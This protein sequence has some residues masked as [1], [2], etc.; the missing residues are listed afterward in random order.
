MADD[1]PAPDL[2][3]PNPNPN[4]N[5]KP[6]P[7]IRWDFLA[8]VTFVIAL[9]FISQSPLLGSLVLF[10]AGTI[11]PV[12]VFGVIIYGNSD[13]R[14]FAIGAAVPTLVM[15]CQAVVIFMLAT[16][17]EW[18]DLRRFDGTSVA[19]PLLFALIPICGGMAVLTRRGV[20]WFRPNDTRDEP[21]R[22]P[23]Q[24]SLRSMIIGTTLAA[25]VC[26]VGMMAREWSSLILLCVMF[27]IVMLSTI[28]LYLA[29]SSD[30]ERAK[31]WRI[32]AVGASVPVFMMFAT[33][34]TTMVIAMFDD[35]SFIDDRNYNSG[36]KIGLP[37]LS[38]MAYGGGRLAVWLNRRLTK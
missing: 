6:Y 24:F 21:S 14:L 38:A 2:A 29:C 35:W 15:F 8:F 10:V 20:E 23:F 19:V 26:F 1:P 17:Q 32:F 31:R 28:G 33:L 7:W 18:D 37:L 3:N 12:I 5:A 25:V 34:V 22:R 11:L 36:L 9:C 30:S 13:Q 16:F 4:P 27:L